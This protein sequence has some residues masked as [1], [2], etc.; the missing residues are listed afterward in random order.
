MT[1]RDRGDRSAL[2][3]GPTPEPVP[4]PH[5]PSRLHTFVWRNWQLVPTATLA[6]V[7][8]AEPEQIR[9]VGA[10]LGLERPPAISPDQLRRTHLTVIRR[11]WHLLP[12]DQLLELLNCSAEELAYTLREDDFF[13][14]KLGLL[15]PACEPLRYAP[16]TPAEER[17]AAEIAALVRG[18]FPAGVDDPGS[19]LQ[20]VSDLSRPPSAPSAPV[21]DLPNRFAERYC[22]SYFSLYGDPLLDL[23]AA[24]YPDGYLARLAEAGVNG[25]WLQA[26]LYRMAPYPWDPARS[27]GWEQRL[28]NLQT[29]IATAARHGIGV[30]LYLNEPRAMPL[31]FFHDRP[32]LRGVTAL[33]H[34][35][36]CTSVPAVREWITGAVAG[37]CRAAPEVRAFFSISAS[38]NLTNCWSHHRGEECPRCGPRGA[39]EVLA[40]V[41]G[42]FRKGIL[43]G[44][45]D[46]TRPRPRLIAWDWGWRD[47][48]AVET[49][50]RLPSDVDV[51]SVSE[52]SIPT[53]RGGVPSEVGEYSLSVIGPGPRARR[54]WQAARDTGHR[55][56]AKI[57]AASTWELS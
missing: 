39:A 55:V 24:G 22:C 5:F 51:M 38:E 40:E 2:P 42:T 50:R 15:K 45:P 53:E 3:A 46:A 35:T 43:Q 37:I 28:E 26:I 17:R 36:L 47:G 13:Y 1:Q 19:L 7:V 57:Q 18:Y 12:Y 25:I 56:L 41:L 34:A 29:L 4:F 16:P 6:Q 21:S 30:F 31:P 52:W 8:G 20:F 48:E 23:E 49:I 9:A 14:V 54:H 33:D 27:E 11:N 10:S 44:C 32:E